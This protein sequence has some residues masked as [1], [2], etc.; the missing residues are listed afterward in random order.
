MIDKPD[1]TDS[2]ASLSDILFT[3]I[4]DEVKTSTFYITEEDLKPGTLDKSETKNCTLALTL[5]NYTL[6]ANYLLASLTNLTPDN[7]VFG[8]K[9]IYVMVNLAHKN[10]LTRGTVC[11]AISHCISTIALSP[12][13]NSPKTKT[14]LISIGFSA[15]SEKDLQRLT[16]YCELLPELIDKCFSKGEVLSMPTGGAS[17]KVH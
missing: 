2:K 7:N 3:S 6:D 12:E 17:S 11:A 15:I 9:T 13:Y 14:K 8:H 5:G 16:T 4:T 1:K 10:A